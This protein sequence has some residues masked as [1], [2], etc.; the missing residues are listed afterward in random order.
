MEF[1]QNMYISTGI[2]NPRRI[3]KD[4]L[5]GKGHLTIWLLVLARG[6]EGRAQLEILHC[7]NFLQP[8]YKDHPVYVVGMASGKADAIEMVNRITQEAFDRTGQWE[9]A[10]YLSDRTGWAPRSDAMPVQ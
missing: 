9:A 2:R 1:Y 6:P 3:K 7:V 8:Y 10:L 4:L 5:R